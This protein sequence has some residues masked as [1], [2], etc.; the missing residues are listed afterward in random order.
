MLVAIQ[1]HTSHRLAAISI[2]KTLNSGRFSKVL[3]DEEST[4]KKKDSNS[5]ALVPQTGDQL[6]EASRLMEIAKLE[7]G[8]EVL[9]L[10]L[11]WVAKPN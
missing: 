7:E 1:A 11:Y 4:G 3:R 2:R 10:H 6:N 5:L 8:K 9:V